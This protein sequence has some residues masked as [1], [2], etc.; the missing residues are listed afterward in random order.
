MRQHII[1]GTTFKRL[2]GDDT[3]YG[4][5]SDEVYQ[6]WEKCP[7]CFEGKMLDGETF[8]RICGLT[9]EQVNVKFGSDMHNAVFGIGVKAHSDIPENEPQKKGLYLRDALE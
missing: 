2:C 4:Y 8:K 9:V 1:D 5:V 3:R 6:T 7:V